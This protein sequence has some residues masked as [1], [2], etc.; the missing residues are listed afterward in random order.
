MPCRRRSGALTGRLWPRLLDRL[1][2]GL[3]DGLLDRLLD[4]F[5]GDGRGPPPEAR[6]NALLDPGWGPDRRRGDQ[7]VL[8]GR[9]HR[10]VLLPALRAGQQV[11]DRS[12]ALTRVLVVEGQGDQVVARVRLR[13]RAPPSSSRCGAWRGRCVA[14]S[15]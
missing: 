1:P 4:R 10:V 3:L 13:H 15:S 14:V 11:L 5:G 12:R 8:D 7:R 6:G 9:G 2:D